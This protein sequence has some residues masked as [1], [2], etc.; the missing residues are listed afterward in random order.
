MKT[1]L[2]AVLALAGCTAVLAV[3]EEEATSWEHA[4]STY[5]VPSDLVVGG[6]FIDRIRPMPVLNGLETN[7]WGGANVVP[8]DADNGLEDPQWSY[9]CMSPVRGPEGREHL[10]AVRWAESA[11]KGHMEWPRSHIVRAT[12]DRPTGPFKVEQEIGPG[13]N[14]MCYRAKDG[15]W[16]LY[17]IGRAYT[18]KSLE[19]PWT[20]YDLKYDLRG[21]KPVPMSNHTFTQREDGSYLMISRGGHVWISV[22]GLQPYRKITMNSAYP[23][24]KGEFED[25]VVW[26]DEVQYNLIVNDWFG[27]TAFYLRSKDGVQWVWDQGKAYDPAVARHEDGTRERWYKF[28]RPNV[29]QDEY[30][31]ATH[32]YFAVIDSRKDLDKGSDNHSS[33]IIALPLTLPRRL[34]IQHDK[35]I[36]AE[37]AEVG[38]LI[39]AEPGFDPQND[40]DLASLRFGAPGAVDYGKGGKLLRHEASGK[41]VLLVFD[42]TA[43]GYAPSDYAGKLLG[44]TRAGD[45]LFGYARL[46]GVSFDEPIIA[47]TAP[48]F[49]G[50][51]IRVH[52]ENF[53]R[54]PTRA[55]RI[56][57]VDAGPDGTPRTNGIAVAPI[58]P[59][60]GV[61][62]V[63]PVEIRAA[64]GRAAMVQLRIECGGSPLEMS[65]PVSILS[66]GGDGTRRLELAAACVDEC[67]WGESRTDRNS[68]GQALVLGSQSFKQGI[69]TH[70]P[71][72]QEWL[73]DG[74]FSE[75]HL[76][77]GVA[78]G[79][80]GSI[81]VEVWGD[82]RPI[83]RSPVLNGGAEP[84]S[85]RVPIQGVRRLALVATDGGNGNAN[86]HVVY[87]EPVLSR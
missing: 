51:G 75:L 5:V 3:P 4:P 53:G 27:R 19:G 63:V 79:Q 74:S 69:G 9:W 35:P 24:I 54:Q 73:L 57:A 26:R 18:A 87:G 2:F 60:E 86:D 30:G 62:V 15:T 36:T 49:V 11:A 81:T 38:V 59:Y 6:A 40:V 32:I 25:P 80:P 14:V 7:V 70:A 42:G 64:A 29:R 10:F 33:K 8:R 21:A 58:A 28:E 16:V 85:L 34:Q 48:K 68:S 67:G 1:H 72:R 31:R 61:D 77:A 46:P 37:T 56:V 13:H 41:D 66:P 52:V 12:A 44:R 55:G 71:S 23:P 39:R 22:D 65:V 82:G 20:P 50:E 43:G 45:L 76:E 17:A 78:A 83:H 47:T 84:L